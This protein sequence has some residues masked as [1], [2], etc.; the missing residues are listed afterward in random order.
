MLAYVSPGVVQTVPSVDAVIDQVI[1]QEDMNYERA[2][3]WEYQQHFLIQKLDSEGHVKSEQ[4]KTV[5]YRPEGRLSFN[6]AAMKGGD[7]KT[8]VG[9]GMTNSRDNSEEGRFSESIKM[10]EL[11]PFYRFTLQGEREWKG[12][13]HWL[14]DFEPKGDV[15]AHG[16]QQKVLSNLKGRLWIDADKKAIAH[17]E[18][19]LYRP[20][21]LMWFN[22]VQLQDLQIHYD[23]HLHEEKVWMP[24]AM[25]LTYCV[26]ILF[27]GQMNERQVMKT[28]N[29]HQ[30][31]PNQANDQAK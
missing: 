14:V 20:I 5:T 23:A 10:R 22:L 27:F 29:F 2:K 19:S 18:C 25:E 13:K 6:V 4:K 30:V 8:Q 7:E 9:I 26:R 17:A 11:R 3:T 15:S 1:Q 28:D 21:H 31:I 12:K 24:E 16:Q